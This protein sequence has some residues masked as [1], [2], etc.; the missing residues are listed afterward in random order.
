VLVMR[1]VSNLVDNAIRYTRA[2]GVLLAGRQTGDG[3]RLQVWDSGRGLDTTQLARLFDGGGRQQR[4]AADEAGL[5]SGLATAK[6]LAARLGGRLSAC[7]RPGR[8]SLFELVLPAPRPADNRH[9][10]WLIIS[11]DGDFRAHAARL[12][13]GIGAS[14][15]AEA[16]TPCA[17]QAAS[18]D[19]DGAPVMIID[20]DELALNEADHALLAPW[21]RRTIVTTYDRSAEMRANL[22]RSCDILLYKPITVAGLQRALDHLA[23]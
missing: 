7:S 22:A 8:G 13:Q 23:A 11:A 21:R 9:P 16:D 10:T 4:F 3:I 2:G 12:A 14:R 15:I 5:G 17:L 6:A 19:A 20:A 1:I 18:G